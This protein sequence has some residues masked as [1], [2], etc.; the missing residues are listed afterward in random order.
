MEKWEWVG[1]SERCFYSWFEFI[2]DKTRQGVFAPRKEWVSPFPFPLSFLIFIQFGTND[3]AAPMDKKQAMLASA[4]RAAR[5]LSLRAVSRGECIN[6]FIHLF[7]IWP[8]QLPFPSLHRPWKLT[9]DCND[10]QLVIGGA[11]RMNE[12]WRAKY[13]ATHHLIC[14]VISITLSLPKPLLSAVSPP[15][16]PRKERM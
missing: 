1:L 16:M 12:F 3:D 15:S 8:L 6:N 14:F 9:I 2:R 11:G 7:Y 4:I 13:L 5:P 10:E